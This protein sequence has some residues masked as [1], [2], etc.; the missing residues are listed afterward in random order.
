MDGEERSTF[1]RG[2]ARRRL[3]ELLEMVA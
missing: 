2:E 3:S 1:L